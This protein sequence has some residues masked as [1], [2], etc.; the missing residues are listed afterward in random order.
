LKKADPD[1]LV[2]TSDQ[3]L[4]RIEKLGD[5]F[6]PVLKLKQKLPALEKLAQPMAETAA[7]AR[8]SKAKRTPSS[9]SRRKAATAPRKRKARIG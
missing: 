7:P 9:R 3:V 4:Q 6:E 8:V 2:F 1:L 5:Q